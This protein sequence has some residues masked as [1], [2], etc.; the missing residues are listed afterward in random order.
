MQIYKSNTNNVAPSLQR[1]LSLHTM[2][3]FDIDL[4]IKTGWKIFKTNPFQILRI[5]LVFLIV[6]LIPQLIVF[7]LKSQGSLIYFFVN[8]IAIFIQLL[9]SI[10]LISIFLDI[11][12]YKIVYLSSLFKSSKIMLM[13]YFAT[14]LFYGI[15]VII[16]LF[17]LIIPGIYL[18]IRFFFA[19]YA[20]ID[21]KVDPIEA[22]AF[23]GKITNNNLLKLSLFVLSI[24]GINVI[25]VLSLGIGLFLTL[26]ISILAII[27]VYRVLSFPF[28]ETTNIIDLDQ[29]E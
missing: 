4:S 26:P 14:S 19:T 20:V 21:K 27:H 17:A 9:T 2:I 15:L 3:Q 1:I 13:S 5:L 24:I 18:F 8:I 29:I 23:S 6:N 22:L 16:G 7:E 25:G 11:Y 28:D 10:G 12:D